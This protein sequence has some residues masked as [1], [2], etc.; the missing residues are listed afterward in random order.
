MTAQIVGP[1]DLL[2]VVSGCNHIRDDH[3]WN[4][5]LKH[6]M[7]TVVQTADATESWEALAS[8]LQPLGSARAVT[9]EAASDEQTTS[10]L[11]CYS[12]LSQLRH[13]I[14]P[15]VPIRT[16]ELLANKFPRVIVNPAS[17]SCVAQADPAIALDEAAMCMVAPFW[18]QEQI[19]VFLAGCLCVAGSTST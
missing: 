6:I 18:E 16:A 14:W 10:R 1:S 13:L 11:P 8:P 7:P 4:V 15:S 17:G 3:A 12:Q 2:L 9:F 19:Q 5:G